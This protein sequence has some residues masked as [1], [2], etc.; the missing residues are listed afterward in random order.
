MHA[1][2][3]YNFDLA[4]FESLKYHYMI[5]TDK[6]LKYQHP[7]N[8]RTIAVFFLKKHV[9]LIFRNALIDSSSKLNRIS[10]KTA[11]K[12]LTIKPTKEAPDQSH[13][14]HSPAVYSIR[15]PRYHRGHATPPIT[16]GKNSYL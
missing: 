11:K 14:Y 10:A 1:L 12:S 9:D 6:H 3:R 13:A 4:S 7:L 15:A 5:S 8:E 2:K 16:L